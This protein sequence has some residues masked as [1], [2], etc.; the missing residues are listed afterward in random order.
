MH[1]NAAQARAHVVDAGRN[2]RE[3]SDDIHA[4]GRQHQGHDEV[5]QDI[6]RAETGDGDH[7]AFRHAPAAQLDQELA[8]GVNEL[9]NL[10]QALAHD[11]LHACHLDATRGRARAAADETDHDQQQGRHARPIGKTSGD[12][13]GGGDVGHHLEAGMA[14]RRRVIVEAAS[15]PD[16]ERH[17]QRCHRDDAEEGAQF[18]IGLVMAHG[19]APPR[20]PVQAVVDAAHQHEHHGNTIEQGA[21]P[22]AEAGVVRGKTTRRQR[23]Q[24]VADG[25][26]EVHAANPVGNGAQGRQSGI[27]QPQRPRGLRD[28][29]RQLAVL[30][31]AGAFGAEQLHAADLEHRQ[32]G[33][34]EDH[35]AHA[36]EEVERLPVEKQAFRQ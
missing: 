36:A 31:R 25:I 22:V 30:G 23:A 5:T 9:F 27:H 20:V 28:A 16:V 6:K 21:V 11:H 12:E 35:D 29:W 3:R 24:R 1:G 32:D 8:L 10:A 15:Q 33:D 7:N 2:G 18:G 17:Q 13:S 26:E 19:G 4:S 14:Q 34:G